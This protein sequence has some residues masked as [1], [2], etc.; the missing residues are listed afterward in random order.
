MTLPLLTRM[1]G[2]TIALQSSE[3]LARCEIIIWPTLQFS[4]SSCTTTSRP[5]LRTDS[6][7]AVLSHGTI[8]RRDRKSTRLNSNHGYISYA[9][10]CLKKKTK[11]TLRHRLTPPLSRLHTPPHNG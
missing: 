7:I 2:L 5:V 10:F 1:G 3:L 9:V 8:E 4:V 6:S 11:L